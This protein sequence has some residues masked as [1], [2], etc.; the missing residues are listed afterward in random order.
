[1]KGKASANVV[2]EDSKF[3]AVNTTVVKVVTEVWSF[4]TT[5]GSD[6]GMYN[7]RKTMTRP[8]S[9]GKDEP[10]T[11]IIYRTQWL[12]KELS[13]NNRIIILTEGDL[14]SEGAVNEWLS[15]KSFLQDEVLRGP[16]MC[17]LPLRID[18]GEHSIR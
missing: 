4:P 5:K 1:M 16:Y 13:H 8:A 3:V 6:R 7:P 15:N 12:V 18:C 17:E 2:W 14:E 11:C 10:E 9:E